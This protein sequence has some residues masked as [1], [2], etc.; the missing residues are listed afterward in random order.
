MCFSA[1]VSLSTYIIGMLGIIRLWNLNLK[2]EAIF[3]AC[4]IQMQLIEFLLWKNNQCNE[5]NKTITKIGIIINHLEPFILWLAIY[6]FS[7]YILP[8]WLNKYMMIFFAIAIFYTYYV[9]KNGCTVVTKES[10]PHLQWDWNSEN[11]N[12]IFYFIFLL[13]LILLS[14]YGLGKNGNTHAFIVFISFV[15]SYLIYNKKHSTGAIWCF[16][17]ASVPWII[18]YVYV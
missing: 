1:E 7:P 15:I 6:S 9:F 8:N 13:A 17:A 4:V 2:P 12:N 16:L 5:M 3:Y 14:S 18:P 11:Y 10:A